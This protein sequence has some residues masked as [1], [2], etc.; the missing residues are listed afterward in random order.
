[1]IRLYQLKNAF[2]FLLITFLTI[3][4]NSD[5]DG[6]D[7][8][9]VSISDLAGS[10]SDLSTLAAA[11]ERADLVDDLDG[12][13]RFTVLAPT[14]SAFALFLDVNDYADIN[15][16]PVDVLRQL[17]LNHVVAGEFR[18]AQLTGQV[19]Y[20]QTSAA[21]PVDNINL[22]LLVNGNSGIV[23]NGMAQV[24]QNGGDIIASN[25]T[26]HIVD[27]VVELPTL[28]TLI[29]GN[30]IFSDL[31]TGLTT[32]TPSAD[33]V[34]ILSESGLYTLFGPADNAFDALFSGN[35]NWNSVEDIDE[36]TLLAVLNHHVIGGANIL[37]SEM[38]N[39][40][41]SP[42]TLE[43]DVLR[44]ATGGSNSIRVADGSGNNNA[45][46]TVGNIQASNGVLHLIDRVLIP[47]T[48]N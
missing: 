7:R 40:Q 1:M 41:E 29:L 28:P 30:P 24:T 32:A 27:A 23:F 16:V 15:A 34:T 14:N 5:D 37:L 13:G 33:Y 6:E 46:I 26:I 36:D 22:S 38:E 31:V 48:E 39:G 12:V 10:T 47:D 19:G 18:S 42:A 4:C 43:G 25:G 45:L 9:D 20:L 3:S 44:F 11:L 21:G 35:P 8:P 17:L 2:F